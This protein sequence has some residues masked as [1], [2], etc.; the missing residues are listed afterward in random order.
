MKKALEA[1]KAE[2]AEHG[3]ADAMDVDEAPAKEEKKEKKKK[4]KSEAAGEETA[5]AEEESPKKKKSKKS[6]D[7]VSLP[8][9][10]ASISMR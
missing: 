6:K 8:S 5:A 3:G 7:E 1:A 9:A 2:A 4:R 10:A